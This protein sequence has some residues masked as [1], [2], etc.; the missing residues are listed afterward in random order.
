MDYVRFRKFL[1]ESCVYEAIYTDSEGREII[2]L[3]VIDAFC[4]VNDAINKEKNHE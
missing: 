1:E 2:V 4:M 3:K